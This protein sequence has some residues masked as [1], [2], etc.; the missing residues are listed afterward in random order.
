MTLH[1]TSSMGA[2][3]QVCSCCGRRIMQLEDYQSVVRFLQ[4]QSAQRRGFQCMNCRLIT[5]FECSRKL[6]RC[7]CGS[8]AWIA[9][10]YVETTPKET[11]AHVTA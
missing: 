10:P 5:C 11:F 4:E 7:A 3:R 2:N 6:K 9:T 1:Q 8:N